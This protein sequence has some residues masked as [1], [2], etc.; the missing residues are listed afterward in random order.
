MLT[1]TLERRVLIYRVLLPG[2]RRG[3]AEEASSF[4][5][6]LT[7]PPAPKAESPADVAPREQ[8]AGRPTKREPTPARP[9]EGPGLIVACCGT[10]VPLPAANGRKCTSLHGIGK[11][12]TSPPIVA[13]VLPCG[14]RMTTS[15]PTTASSV[16]YMDCIEVCPV[17]CF[18]EGENSARHPS[19]RMYRLRRVRA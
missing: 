1:I 5:K 16:S 6:T 2:S 8:G 10:N 11:G 17:D 3:P 7:P 18:Y 19:R 15:S 14:N 12:A 9:P 4:T 13:S